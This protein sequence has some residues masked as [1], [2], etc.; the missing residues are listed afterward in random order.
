M[1]TT[2]SYFN[3]DSY[4]QEG[5]KLEEFYKEA[6]Y[7]VFLESDKFTKMV[8]KVEKLLKTNPSELPRWRK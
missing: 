8:E 7:E 1:G 2:L 6:V 5:T 4:Q 3:L